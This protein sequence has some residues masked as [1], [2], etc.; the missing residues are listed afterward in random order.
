MNHN[1]NHQPPSPEAA[2]LAMQRVLQAERDAERAVAACEQEARDILKAAQ[3]RAQH[4][5]ARTNA[6]ISLL[7]MNQNQ[8][9]NRVIRDIEKAGMPT[10]HPDTAA[11]FDAAEFS[12]VIDELAAELTTGETHAS[13]DRRA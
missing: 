10:Q 9:L 1:N 8:K 11:L 7:Q 4:L 3:L 2:D 6:R 13:E 12:A 5:A